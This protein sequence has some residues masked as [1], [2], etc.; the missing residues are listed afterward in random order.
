MQEF[1]LHGVEMQG[2]CASLRSA[3]C[4]GKYASN[5]HRDIMRKVIKNDP[6]QAYVSANVMCLSIACSPQGLLIVFVVVGVQRSHA[7]LDCIRWSSIGLKFL[8]KS[9][10]DQ[11]ELK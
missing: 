8:S 4:S 5:V 11:M 6:N 9:N 10:M 3:G 7:L 1:K 2:P